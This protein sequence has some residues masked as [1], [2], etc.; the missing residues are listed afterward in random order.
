MAEGFFTQSWYRVAGLRP[1]IANHVTVARH[2]Y[3]SQSW[4]ALGDPLS[5]RVHRV[6]P[7][8]YLFA[9]RLDGKRTVDAVWQEMVAEMDT[10]APGQETVVSL[11]MQLHGADLLA[12]DIPP[13]A[14]ELLS[15]RDR[16]TRSIWVRNLRSPLSMQIPLIDPDRFLTRTLPLVQP[17]FSWFAIVAWL[18]LMAA[19]LVTVG[20]HWAELTENVLDR[21][22]AAEGL[23]T[24]AL[25]YPIIKVLHELG[26]GYAAKRFGCEVREMG[27]MML[28]LFPVPY[29]DASSSAALRSKWQRAGVAAAGIIVELTLA[30]I[31]ALV[32]AEAEPGI[33]RALAFNVM[34]I[35]GVSTLI[36]NGNPLLRFDGYYVLSDV[37]EVPNL[38][39]R[40]TRYLGYLINRYAFRVPGLTRFT[41]AG[42]ERAAFLIYAPVSWCYRLAVMLGVTVF[43]ATHYFV[44]GVGIGIFTITMG[45]LVPMAKALWQ[46]AMGPRYRVCR[47]RAAGL[48]FGGIAVVAAAVL[49]VPA[50]VHST[51]EGVIWVPREAIVRAGTDGFVRAVAAGPGAHVV[52]GAALFVL[53][54]PIAEAKLRVTAARVDELQAKYAA[55][56]VDDR[57]AA[58]VTKFE[59]NQEQASLAREQFRNSRHIVPAASE[60]T[61]NAIRPVADMVG[62]YVK[63]GEIMGYVTPVSGRVARVVVPQSDIGLVQ[64]HLV[65]VMVRLA[66]RHTDLRS[67]VVRAVPAAEQNVPSQALTAASGGSISTDPR[68][69]KGMKAFERLFQFD[70]ALPD[71]GPDVGPG[72][73]SDAAEQAPRDKRPGAEAEAPAGEAA[74]LAASGFGARVYVR[75]DFTWEPIGAMLY[76]RVR[77]GLLTRFET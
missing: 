36:V 34:L 42:H 28:V 15:R 70:V 65:D 7:A 33:L 47:G 26:H 44:L 73:G 2:R 24:L 52:P 57:I 39:Q 59:L 27:V 63:E 22:M 1:R 23:V 5:G 30:A 8:A 43:V 37:I 32:W 9:A 14:A 55:Q 62:R 17:L 13:D 18:V 72:V 75:F 4:Y 51:T 20:E 54:H 35:G 12:G 45:F 64:D 58:E 46:V 50:P 40:G 21:V 6:T 66:D 69:N 68:D 61:F 67:S 77:Q 48:T 25:C 53:E 38:A 10:E 41:A 76:R 16:L 19:A 56:W 74:A 11:L 29:V 31:A 71:V 49:A 3:G 60:G